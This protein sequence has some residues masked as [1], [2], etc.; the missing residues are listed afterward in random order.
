[1]A[2]LNLTGQQDIK[3]DIA[4]KLLQL[5]QAMEARK[6]IWDKLSIEKKKKWITSGKDPVMNISWDVYNYLRNKF[7]GEETDNG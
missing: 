2:T 5:K 1:M 4:P 7:F 3:N 6:D